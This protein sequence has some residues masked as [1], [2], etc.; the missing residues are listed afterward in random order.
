MFIFFEKE[1]ILMNEHEKYMS[2]AVAL[3]RKGIGFV[4]P[5]PLVGAVIVKDGEIIGEGWHA[6][7]GQLHAERNAFA[8]L[9]KSAEG[10]DM[11]VT[12]EPCCHYGKTP[13]C[14]EAVIENKI[15]RVFIGSDDPNPKVAGKGINILRQ[16]GI[17]VV[18]G[19]LKHEC[20]SLNE[21]F[22]HYISTG[23]PYVILKYAMTADGKIA[24]VSGNSKWITSE[25]SRNHVQLTRKRVAAIMVGSGTVIA[26]DPLL[27]CRTENP[28]NPVRVICDSRLSIPPECRILKTAH[29]IP[30]YIATVS[31][32]S[33][34]IKAV[35]QTG[36]HIIQTDPA[37]SRVNLLQLMKILGEKKIDSLL[38]EGGSA[39]SY[40]AV[41][42][43]I[44]N[45]VQA[46][47]APKIFGGRSALSPVGGEG[48]AMPDDAFILSKPKATAIG[49]D[50]LLEYDFKG[51]K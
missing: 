41:K 18:T 46:Y 2:M 34:R 14:T 37:D 13:P 22:F 47:I 3:A 45:K 8:S 6:K 44:V 19:V 50:I 12:L 38:I 40:S 27:T 5:N 4:N 33:D 16:N 48:V 32:D 51:V 15:K 7:Y 35:E 9:T 28:S 20:D 49:D 10:A 11:Y 17:E 36:A 1:D 30:T 29:E 43:G 42:C 23:M 31:N 39:L 24:S 21:I 25:E 26:D